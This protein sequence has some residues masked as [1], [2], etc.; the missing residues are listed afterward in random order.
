MCYHHR[1]TLPVRVLDI[2]CKLCVSA[3]LFAAGCSLPQSADA[4]IGCGV[5]PQASPYCPGYQAPS[6]GTGGAAGSASDA[7]LSDADADTEDGGQ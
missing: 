4:E 3:L 5:N 2:S 1:Q 7:G 6:A